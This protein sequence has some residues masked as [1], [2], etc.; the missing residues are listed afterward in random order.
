MAAESVVILILLHFIWMLIGCWD[1]LYLGPIC[2]A[3]ETYLVR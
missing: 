1:V 3:K 2:L